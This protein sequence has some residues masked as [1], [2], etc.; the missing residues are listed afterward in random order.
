MINGNSFIDNFIEDFSTQENI[1][2]FLPICS[3]KN[4]IQE[5]P[6]A[7]TQ[8]A[9]RPLCSK[10][11]LCCPNW[12]T[13]PRPG[14]P[15]SQG[16]PPARVP[17]PA[18]VP[19]WGGTPRPGYPPSQGTP[20]ARVPPGQGTPL[21]RVPPWPGYPQPGYPPGQ[22]TPR[23]GYPPWPGYPPSWTWQGTPPGYTWQGTPPGCP[24]AFWEMLQSIM[25]YGYPPP[26]DR[27]IDGWM[28]GQTRV[29][30]LPSRRTTYAGGNKNDIFW[31]D[32]MHPMPCPDS[33]VTINIIH[34]KTWSS[35][36]N[37]FSFLLVERCETGPKKTEK[38]IFYGQMDLYWADVWKKMIPEGSSIVDKIINL[39]QPSLL[40]AFKKR[41]YW[42]KDMTWLVT[43]KFIY[44][45]HNIPTQNG[46]R[47]ATKKLDNT[48]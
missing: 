38:T 43:L 7:W 1:K 21:A 19:P 44:Q 45:N 12:V 42:C 47:Q 31:A 26:V 16:T 2:L 39:M 41:L 6:P 25:G 15:P 13:P 18:R 36:Q 27:Q 9:Y 35:S 23:P 11:S 30:T 48:A 8:E 4:Y 28:D 40:T 32:S 17:T 33:W 3:K 34:R 29:K 5:S 10:Y 46:K 20:P 37:I 24:M 22:G 14:Y